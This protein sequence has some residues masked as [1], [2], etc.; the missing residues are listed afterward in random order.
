MFGV[1]ALACVVT[2]LAMLDARG[3]LAQTHTDLFPTLPPVADANPNV[4]EKRVFRVPTRLIVERSKN[5]I[6][7]SVDMDSLEQIEIPVGHKMICAFKH[8]FSVESRKEK[9]VYSSGLGGSANLGAFITSALDGIPKEG[10]KYIVELRLILF[11]TDIPTQHFWK[12]ESGRYREIWSR[13]IRS[14]E[15]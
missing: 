15:L 4:R 2:V 8:E 9:K 7:V 10:E 3:V 14:K 11:E 6:A 1:H 12:P 5:K 13:T